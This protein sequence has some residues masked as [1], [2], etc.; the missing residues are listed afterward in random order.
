MKMP[1]MLQNMLRSRLS[2]VTLIE[3]VEWV[4]LIGLGTAKHCP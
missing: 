1:S 2:A 3:L 4:E